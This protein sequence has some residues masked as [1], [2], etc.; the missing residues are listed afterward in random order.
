MRNQAKVLI[1]GAGPAGMA[2]AL[3]LAKKG[4][5]STIIE[6]EKFPR[7]KICGDGLSGWVLAMLD[8]L[9][10]IITEKL[11][12]EPN[13]LDSWGMRFFAPNMKS[14]LLPYRNKKQPGQA[15]GLLMKRIDFDHFLYRE[16]R[17]NSLIE[18]FEETEINHFVNDDK[19]VL[20]MDKSGK[21]KFRGDIVVFADGANSRFAR[22][23]GGIIKNDKQNAVGIKTYFKGIREQGTG[24]RE[25][26]TVN[27][28]QGTV[29]GDVGSGISEKGGNAVEF[30]FLK[31]I[32]PGYLWIFPLANGEANVGMGIR[33]DIIKKK[34]INLKSELL[35][36][37][38]ETPE[39]KDRFSGAEQIGKFQS[40]GLPLGSKKQNI[41][42]DRFLMAGDAAFLI[43]PFTG[44]GVGNALNSGM[45]AAEHIADAVQANRF[46]S[47]FNNKYD[48]RVY[49]KLWKEL[50]V[51]R[52]IQ[53]ML[54]YPGLINWLM[55]RAVNNESL[56]GS[57]IRMIDNDKERK[58]LHR[59]GF[60]VRVLFSRNK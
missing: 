7:D 13:I 18:I 49:D 12:K 1:V 48:K 41:S 51:S 10:P 24:N 32:L 34:K 2:T 58:K 39:L 8:K 50:K 60:Y 4:I 47:E 21:K 37:I 17:D 45:H 20:L 6:K 42:G 3:F 15:P 35:R 56:T 23:P 33:T 46:D 38:E 59:P 57:F 5:P 14:I 52:R 30:Y 44:E 29:D 53:K 11:R 26:G 36:C 43:D 19:G 22:E 31:S 54:K 55:N 25:W 40:W 16:V 28:E 9:D 27:G